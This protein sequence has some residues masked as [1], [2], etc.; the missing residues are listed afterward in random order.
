M[1]LEL[2]VESATRIAAALIQSRATGAD[3]QPLSGDELATRAVTIA[4]KIITDCT[5]KSMTSQ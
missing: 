3:G 4:A 2:L 1:E 5:R